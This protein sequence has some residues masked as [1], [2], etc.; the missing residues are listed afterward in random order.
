M[1]IEPSPTFRY[2][3]IIIKP[4]TNHIARPLERSRS[5]F[6]QGLMIV[7]RNALTLPAYKYERVLLGINKEH[8]SCICH[9]F[10]AL[11]RTVALYFV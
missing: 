2:I 6:T 1:S 3:C 11:C 9:A 10:G 4:T 8:V 5:A 7:A